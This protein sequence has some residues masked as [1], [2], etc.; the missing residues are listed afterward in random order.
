MQPE[1]A[2]FPF[3]VA[4]FYTAVFEIDPQE[5]SPIPALIERLDEIEARSADW[6]EAITLTGEPV[7]NH[8]LNQSSLDIRDR[9]FPLLT[10]LSLLLLGG[11]FRC[12]RVLTA[13]A[14]AVGASL[15]TAMGL[16]HLMG[17]SM[18]LVTTLIPV[19]IFV[20]S[21]AMQV[22]ILIAVAEKDQLL[23]GIATKLRANL[24]VTTTT[25]IGFGSLMTSQVLPLAV[26]GRY[27]A[28]SMWIIF[29]GRTLPISVS[30]S[31]R[32]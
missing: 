27:M 29:F 21:V 24:L 3:Q 7:V 26:M 32:A 11:L 31:W 25:S 5:S 8:L 2:P 4:N 12:F 17:E 15:A 30:H 14:L 28:I 20:L 13:T 16:L 18:N 6:L 1:D 19:L 10:V 23:E 9:L 22:H